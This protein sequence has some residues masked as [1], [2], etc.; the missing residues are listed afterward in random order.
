MEKTLD[1]QLAAEMPSS[2]EGKYGKNSQIG[3]IKQMAIL[4]RIK[5]LQHVLVLNSG[6]VDSTKFQYFVNTLDSIEDAIGK[7][8]AGIIPE[9]AILMRGG[10]DFHLEKAVIQ[11]IGGGKLV[12]QGYNGN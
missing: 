6:K 1:N 10:Q 12:F 11:D 7:L 8:D 2:E 5:Y 3:N 4:L 9:T